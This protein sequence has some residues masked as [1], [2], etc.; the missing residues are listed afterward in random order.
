MDLNWS[1]SF[2]V[3][4]DCLERPALTAPVV[5]QLPEAESSP[6]PRPNAITLS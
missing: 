6:L 5:M 4:V 1:S 3:P 2:G